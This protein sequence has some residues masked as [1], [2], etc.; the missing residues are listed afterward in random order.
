VGGFLGI[1]GMGIRV[2]WCFGG[3]APGGWAQWIMVGW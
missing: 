1:E 2:A 3:L